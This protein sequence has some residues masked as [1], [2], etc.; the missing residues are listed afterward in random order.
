MKT[1]GEVEIYPHILLNLALDAV[2]FLDSPPVF[3]KLAKQPTMTTRYMAGWDKN[4]HFT[5]RNRT[6]GT[7]TS[8][9]LS[10]HY[11]NCFTHSVQPSEIVR[12]AH[13]KV[14]RSLSPFIR[15]SVFGKLFIWSI[16]ENKFHVKDLSKGKVKPILKT[17]HE[18]PEGE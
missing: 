1:W 5:S 13:F 15:V 10:C 12:N 14:K 3:I 2:N 18:G 4:K 6:K 7:R 9:P 17:D 8:N 11:T 16:E